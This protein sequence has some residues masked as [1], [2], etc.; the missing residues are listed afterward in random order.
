MLSLGCLFI[1][2]KQN[3]DQSEKALQLRNSA[4]QQ[5]LDKIDLSK[6]RKEVLN[7]LNRCVIVNGLKKCKIKLFNLQYFDAQG[8]KFILLS[9]YKLPSKEIDPRTQHM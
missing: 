9:F 3:F 6:E 2:A 4:F 7:H 5:K 1:L 8:Y